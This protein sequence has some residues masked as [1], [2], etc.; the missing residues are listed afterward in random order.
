MQPNLHGLHGV[1]RKWW[2]WFYI[3]EGPCDAECEEY[4]IWYDM[5]WYDVMRYD[6]IWWIQHR[7]HICIMYTYR[8][9]AILP[10]S[11]LN[12]NFMAGWMAWSA[13]MELLLSSKP[14]LQDAGQPWHTS[15]TTSCIWFINLH[16]QFNSPS[17]F[18]IL[19]FL[20]WNHPSFVPERIEK[21]HLQ[22]SQ[23]S[24]ILAATFEASSFASTDSGLRGRKKCWSQQK[25]NKTES[26]IFPTFV[27]G[28][29][30]HQNP[31]LPQFLPEYCAL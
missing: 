28:E 1:T 4:M 23:R 21:H 31:D 18:Y 20:W 16:P 30:M 2:H 8:Q 14:R 15:I 13:Q 11:S 6:M 3:S 12:M 10:F 25:G 29:S 26:V 17:M 22:R 27:W 24:A 19:L 7:V 9:L 5:I